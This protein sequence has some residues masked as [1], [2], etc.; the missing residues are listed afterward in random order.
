M[1]RFRFGTELR[2]F[3][4]TR[5]SRLAIIAATCIPLLYGALYL[6]AFWNP[7]DNL[8]KVPVALVNADNGAMKDDQPIHAGRDLSDKLLENKAL[9][10][11]RTSAAEARNGLEEG[12]YFAVLTIPADFSRAVTTMGTS[13]PVSAPLEVTYDDAQGYTARTILGSVMREVRTAAADAIGETAVDKLFIGFSDIHAGLVQAHD[14]ASQLADGTAKAAD[15]SRQLAEGAHTLAINERK[16][17]EGAATLHSGT[18]T[19]ANGARELASKTPDLA[20]G[21][22]QLSSGLITAKAGAH[23]I[24][25]AAQTAADKSADIPTKMD[26]LA[27]GAEQVAAGNAK[28]AS[29]ADAAQ[30]AADTSLTQA[31]Q[32]VEQLPPGDPLREKLLTQIST[33]QTKAATAREQIDK[34]SAGS[35]QIA[36]YNRQMATLAPLAVSGLRTAATATGQLATGLD[37]ASDGAVK[38]ADGATR[39]DQAIQ[40]LSGGLTSIDNG[41][42]QLDTGIHQLADG[43]DTLAT[44][45]AELRDG[46]G[47]L[48]EGSHTL[49]TKLGEAVDKVPHLTDDER[50]ANAK[51]MSAPV[52]LNQEWSHRAHS[53]GEGFAP[54]FVGLALY[55]GAMILWMLLRPIST[56]T[57]AAPVTAMRVVLSNWLPAIVLGIGQALLLMAV[58]IGALGMR[59]VHLLVTLAFTILV[60]MAYVTLQQTFNIM[61][62]SAVGRVVTLVVLTLQITSSGGTYPAETSPGFFQA[63][64]RTLPLTQVVNGLRCA[65]TGDLNQQ[66]WYATAYLVV[67][68]VASIAVSTFA[69]ARK[70]VWSISRLHPAISL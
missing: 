12:R 30:G 48:D 61:L 38:L 37:S 57:L 55:V 14:G 67:L 64:H 63:L 23:A 25:N 60:S 11:R 43:S 42:A 21:A 59:P 46:L 52:S 9:D 56:R 66:F 53:Q 29:T 51:V 49:S 69:A 3:G 13:E 39:T 62:G 16:A 22:Q 2:R 36:S 24:H 5:M 35:T 40:Q 54:Y 65:I 33:A 27:T 6:W 45:T 15:G 17:A 20:N 68:A 47:K 28:L 41:A 58:L 4:R 1:S 70:R 8:D 19:A 7:T 50:G 26:Q 34:L 31:R 32:L 44:K 18:T 10:W